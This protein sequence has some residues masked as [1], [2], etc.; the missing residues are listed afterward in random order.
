MKRLVC[1]FAIL[2]ILAAGGAL[3]ADDYVTVA[4]AVASP[5]VNRKDDLDKAYTD[6]QTMLRIEMARQRLQSASTERDLSATHKNILSHLDACHSS[7]EE[8]RRLDSN[9]PDLEK[10]AKKALTASPA[11]VRTDPGT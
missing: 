5:L 6:A 2:A 1:L 8:I 11:L 4:S 7:M 3:R 9:V 10:I